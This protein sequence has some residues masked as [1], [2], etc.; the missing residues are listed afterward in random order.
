MIRVTQA[1]ISVCQQIQVQNWK[2]V[3]WAEHESDDWFCVD[4]VVGGYDADEG[5][6]CFSVHTED[7]EHW[8][9]FTLPQAYDILE[10]KITELPS[11]KADE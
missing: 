4:D 9:Q 6:F 5:A 7:G 3:Q 2:E 10:G 1:I 11:R 8:F